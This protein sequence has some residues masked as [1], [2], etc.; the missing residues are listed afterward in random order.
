MVVVDPY[1]TGAMLVAEL[2]K[3]GYH[4]LALWTK[5]VQEPLETNHFRS[6][7]DRFRSIL[8]HF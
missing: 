7:L 5:E 1:S 2:V 4:V 6:I 3:R 8:D